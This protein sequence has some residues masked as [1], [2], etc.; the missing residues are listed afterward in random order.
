M[1][2][3]LS[4]RP[5]SFHCHHGGMCELN[6]SGLVIKRHLSFPASAL[7]GAQIVTGT[8]KNGSTTYG[9]DLVTSSGLIPLQAAFYRSDPSWAEAQAARIEAFAHD[10]K[11]PE[12]VIEDDEHDMPY[13]F[14]GLW[15]VVIILNVVLDWW[16][17]R[18]V[19]RGIAKRL[20]A[21][22]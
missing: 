22:R 11:S 1:P 12:L 5:L 13:V 7:R 2:L 6:E 17:S 16:K 19:R 21:G 15:I 9:L 14:V 4:W 18:R 8:G 20:G 10:P 3:T